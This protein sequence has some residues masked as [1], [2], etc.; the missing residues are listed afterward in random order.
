MQRHHTSTFVGMA[1][2]ISF[3]GSATVGTGAEKP[4][5]SVIGQQHDLSLPVYAPPKNLLPR[6]RVGGVLRGRETADAEIVALVPDHVGLTLKQTPTLNWF[7]S[8]PTSYPLKFTIND[9]RKVRPIYEGPLSTPPAAGVHTID[10]KALGLTLE[11]N[12][13][14][15]WFVS[16]SP[17]P[18][19]HAPDIV[20]GGMIER[21][22]FNECIITIEPKMTC[23]PESVRTNATIGLWYD[24]MGCVCALIEKDQAD[25]TLRRLRAALLR[26]VGLNGVAD[27][28]LNS[29]QTKAR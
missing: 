15:R 29:I 9:D 17:D 3:V 5:P 1:L 28:D 6:A 13:Q 12:I 27:W 7:L 14:Y 10:L 23:D 16:A 26:Q 20:A 24:A 25:P 2:A 19:S 4:P 21:C 18:S 22:E 11:P 8:K